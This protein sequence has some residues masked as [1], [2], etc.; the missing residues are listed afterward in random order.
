MS[1]LAVPLGAVRSMMLSM[2]WREG[3]QGIRSVRR[4]D[5]LSRRSL[6]GPTRAGRHCG[7]V[8]ASPDPTTPRD[9]NQL[10]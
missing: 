7:V 8:V 6:S 5:G 2:P 1:Q 10:Y 9:S 4:F 3:K